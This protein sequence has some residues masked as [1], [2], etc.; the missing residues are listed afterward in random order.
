MIISRPRIFDYAK[1]GVRAP[2][3]G[4]RGCY[5]PPVG[6]AYGP[7]YTPIWPETVRWFTVTRTENNIC[8]HQYDGGEESHF[9]WRFTDGPNSFHSWPT[10]DPLDLLKDDPEKSS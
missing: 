6:Y 5:H 10:R 8:H 2:H 9:I 3:K 4:E 1:A 7:G